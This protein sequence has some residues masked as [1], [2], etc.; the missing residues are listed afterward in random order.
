MICVDLYA[1]T[2]MIRRRHWRMSAGNKSQITSR[3]FFT[4]GGPQV[5]ASAQWACMFNCAVVPLQFF[6][7]DRFALCHWLVLTNPSACV[8]T[9]TRRVILGRFGGIGLCKHRGVQ[10][11]GCSWVV[12]P[13]PRHLQQ[14]KRH[15]TLARAFLALGDQRGAR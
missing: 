6:G 1:W 3:R 9:S 15:L 11:S 7:W 8:L 2:C 5:A 14:S 13:T 4:L 10:T 12:I